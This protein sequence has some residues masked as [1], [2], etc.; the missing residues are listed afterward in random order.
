MN[1]ESKIEAAVV[2]V[3]RL[4]ILQVSDAN[5]GCEMRILGLNLECRGIP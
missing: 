5:M 2:R 1:Y 3:L 4:I